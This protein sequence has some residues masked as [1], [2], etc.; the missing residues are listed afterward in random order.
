MTKSSATNCVAT[1]CLGDEMSRTK[2]RWDEK[3]RDKVSGDEGRIRFGMLLL[4][5][6]FWLAMASSD[7]VLLKSSR[8]TGI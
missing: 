4:L 5:F 6:L 3:S 1:N 7:R 2:S 8:K